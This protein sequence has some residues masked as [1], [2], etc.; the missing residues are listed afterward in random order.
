MTESFESRHRPEKFSTITIQSELENLNGSR[1]ELPVKIA[2]D[3]K[4]RAM[5]FFDIDGTLAELRFIHDRAISQLYPNHDP[6]EV[7]ET[8]FNGYKLGNSYREHWRM[9]GIFNEGRKDW[10]D[11]EIYLAWLK[12]HQQEVDAP[13]HQF[14]DL[15]AG[16]LKRYGEVAVKIVEETAKTEPEKFKTA[17]NQPIFH[18]A[19]LY[20]RLGIPM[21]LMTANEK[22]LAQA[23][24]KQLNLGE[25]FLDLATD[26]TME[27]GG[28][29]KA[30]N[31]LMNRL[32][33]KGVPVPTDRL[34][35]VGDSLRGD[36]GSLAKLGHEFSGQGIVVVPETE[37]LAKLKKQIDGQD[38]LR[39][40]IAD[41]D[42]QA[43]VI[44]QVPVNKQGRPMLSSLYR[45]R[46]LNKLSNEKLSGNP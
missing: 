16:Y 30:M 44:D 11:P 6:Q 28:K 33:Q 32:A 2:E 36:V 5:A 39:Q 7:A 21:V 40:V 38:D 24:A 41:L 3:G 37:S 46:F 22:N 45:H 42:T 1:V 25:M 29:E 14:H 17:I 10:Q 19:E 15:A 35:V 27:G 13:G 4:A 20:R 34:I 43:L 12:D 23:M 8:F 9:H 26:E 31:Y 18:L